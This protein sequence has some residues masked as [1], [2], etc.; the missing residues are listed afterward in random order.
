LTFQIDILALK[1]NHRN[2]CFSKSL[3]FR[4]R[5]LYGSDR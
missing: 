1:N 5:S 2:L 3:H 4:L